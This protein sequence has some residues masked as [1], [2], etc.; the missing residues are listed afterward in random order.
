MDAS[1]LP[2]RVRQRAPATYQRDVPIKA[3]GDDY[4][5]TRE[6]H[7]RA[8]CEVQGVPLTAM[9]Q[10]QADVFLE[11]WAAV[12]NATLKDGVQ[13]VS[14]SR[15]NGLQQH[16]RERREYAQQ[17]FTGA[18]LAP[19]REMAL[20]SARHVEA[21]MEQGDGRDLQLFLCVPAGKGQKRSL[22]QAVEVY[23]N[24][25][26][27]AGMALRRLGEPELSLI[28]ARFFKSNVPDFWYYALGRTAVAVGPKTASVA[29]ADRAKR[30]VRANV[31]RARRVDK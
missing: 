6:G 29:D 16:I 31:G 1:K 9:G 25:Y 26:A 11:G 22:D 13:M 21:R 12:L 27:Q 4:L 2:A 15:P 3:I 17:H 7:L 10:Q 23:G 19:Y 28:Y 18:E 30:W 14:R 5:L 20:A 24:L 8:V